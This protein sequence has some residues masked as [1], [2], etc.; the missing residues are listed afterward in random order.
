MKATKRDAKIAA[1]KLKYE[2]FISS[3]PEI[4]RPKIPIDSTIKME[5]FVK[6]INFILAK[7][8]KDGFSVTEILIII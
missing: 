8:N 3:I 5:N 6:N 7:E 1:A 4:Y 2:E